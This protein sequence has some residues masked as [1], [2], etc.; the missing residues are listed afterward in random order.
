MKKERR[1]GGWK[2]SERERGEGEGVGNK[3]WD[4]QDDWDDWLRGDGGTKEERRLTHPVGPI[5]FHCIWTTVERGG[6]AVWV[7]GQQ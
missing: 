6:S 4:C 2:V 5:L 1:K 7:Q 3:V